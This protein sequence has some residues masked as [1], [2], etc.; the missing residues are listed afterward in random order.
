MDIYL[1]LIILILPL[2]AQLYV[3]SAYN[4]NSKIKNSNNITGKDVA[5]RILDKNGLNNISINQ[6]S[7]N[8]T[9]YYN[10]KTKS[11]ALS[12]DVF[13][14]NSI[15]AVSVA[16][17][18]VGHAIQ[19]KDGYSFFRFRTALVPIVNFSSRFASICIILGF[20]F[21]FLNLLDIGIIL[22]LVGLFFQLVT[23]PV[24]FNA[25]ARAKKEL[26]SCGLID[27]KD[28]NGTA[29]VLNAAAFTYVA[30]FLATALQIL[31]LILIRNRD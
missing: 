31:R 1:I 29:S 7:G 3:T 26:I 11:I 21:Q 19:D 10:P 18:E 8:L 28:T 2:V 23:L 27:S 15:A 25:S 22:L 16:A 4:K 12:R 14:G 13:N 24:E 20:A 9:D 17:H 30:G 6:I 5:Q